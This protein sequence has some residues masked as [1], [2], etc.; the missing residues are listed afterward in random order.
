MPQHTQQTVTIAHNGALVNAIENRYKDGRVT[1]RLYENG[2]D[3][4]PTDLKV[5]FI[6]KGRVGKVFSDLYNQEYQ[7]YQYHFGN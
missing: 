2:L 5:I 1:Q 6:G 3:N 4:A 7:Q